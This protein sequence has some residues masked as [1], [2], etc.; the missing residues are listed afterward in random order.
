MLET[1]V[2]EGGEEATSSSDEDF[3]FS[4]DEFLYGSIN[5]KYNRSHIYVLILSADVIY[6]DYIC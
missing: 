6:I 3:E 1:I 2:S 5:C 4:D